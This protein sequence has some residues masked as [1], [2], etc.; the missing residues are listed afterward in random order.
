M[1]RVL[2]TINLILSITVLSIYAAEYTLYGDV[3][4]YDGTSGTAGTPN[5]FAS[6]NAYRE[7]IAGQI[8]HQNNGENSTFPHKIYAATGSDPAYFYTDVG[9][10]DWALTPPSAGQ[11]IISVIEVFEPENGW[12]GESYVA[13][14]TTVI[15]PAD[16]TNSQT[17]VPPVKLQLLPAPSILVEGTNFITIGWTGLDNDFIIGYTL[18]R[19]DDGGINYNPIT[20]TGQAKGALISYIDNDPSLS[21]G[22]TYYYKISVNF[23]WGGGGGAPEYYETNAKSK[24]SNGAQIYPETSTPTYTA[25][26]TETPTETFTFT[27]TETETQTPTYTV[28]YTFTD[29]ETATITLT[30]TYTF[31]FSATATETATPSFTSTMTI[32]ATFTYTETPVPTATDTPALL[33]DSLISNVGKHKVIIFNNPVKNNEI[34]LGLYSEEAGV[35]EIY[36]YNIK[37]ELVKKIYISVMAGVNIINQELNNISSG[38]YVLN[39]K[40]NNKN[41]PLRKISVVK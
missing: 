32:T 39:V 14:T 18:Y 37:A 2:L 28:T 29:T 25:T 11:V 36:I 35:A 6:L 16:I 41:L 27:F 13:C 17:N 23:D 22:I 20:I 40:I 19:S 31:T 3:F 34:K 38:V 33:S 26:Y 1:K 7:G 10:S 24:A 21:S 8:G 15:T 9:S 5:S 30:E 12:S 4:N